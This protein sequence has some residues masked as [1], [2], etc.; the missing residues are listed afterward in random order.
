M[1]LESGEVKLLLY[2]HY[3]APRIGGVETI[4]STLAHAL[5][6]LRQADGNPEFDITLVTSTPPDKF[7]DSQMPFRIIREPGTLTLWRLISAADVIHVAGPAFT[8]MLM[9]LLQRKPVIVEHHGFQTICPTG[10]LVREPDIQP[11][12]GHFMAG[13]HLRCLRCSMH[14]RP[15]ALFRLW[16]FTFL[17]RFLCHHVA[18][19]IVPTAWLADQLCLPHS[20]TVYHGIP[21]VSFPAPS[22]PGS[23]PRLVF[24][25]RLVTAK[26]IRILL[27][28]VGLLKSK[29]RT[30]EVLVIGDGPDRNALQ[31]HV[32]QTGNSEQ[33]HFLGRLSDS[34]I[35]HTLRRTDI[36]VAP[37]LG[38]EVFGM[39]LVENMLR[40]LPIVASD[41]GSYREVL[42]D[43]GVTF[44][45]A[46]AG[47][48]ALRI[49]ALFADPS[50]LDRLGS[51][52]RERAL[53]FFNVENMVEKHADI[54]RRFASREHQ[55]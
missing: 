22:A 1:I 46:D 2:S 55:V 39:I 49:S 13:E 23:A 21:A 51:K 16:I 52:A 36:L 26:G 9:G 4:V 53:L 24:I 45:V 20:E 29:G 30:C 33:V 25:G 42:D 31:E 28:A 37:S 6:Q 44:R 43:S 38:G 41:L 35:N 34:E 54:Y 10:Q 8:P 47:D 17:R 7:E 48:L 12:P 50:V 14:P 32:Q 5:S 27:D 40:G 11:C 18:V 3:F 15:L 19:N